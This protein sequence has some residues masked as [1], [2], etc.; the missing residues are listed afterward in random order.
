MEMKREEPIMVI[1]LQDI[2]C[3]YMVILLDNDTVIE[4]STTE[5]N[6]ELRMILFEHEVQW[7]ERLPP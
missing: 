1:V 4:D 3:G 6:I 2:S 7:I 5:D